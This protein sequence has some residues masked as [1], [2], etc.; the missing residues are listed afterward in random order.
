MESGVLKKIVIENHV[1]YIKGVFEPFCEVQ[2]LPADQITPQ[3][4]ADADALIV[5]TRNKC[6]NT[7]LDGSTV[8]LIATATIGTD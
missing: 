5:R 7:L 8:K 4:V 2:Y 6:N 1:P 3:S